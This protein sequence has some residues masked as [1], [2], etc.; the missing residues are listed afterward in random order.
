MQ[1]VREEALPRGRTVPH[2]R[3]QGRLGELQPL[4]EPGTCPEGD[5]ADKRQRLPEMTAAQ[6]TAGERD[7]LTCGNVVFWQHAL[8]RW[9]QRAEALGLDGSAAAM[10]RTFKRAVPEM[11]R[12]KSVRWN[13]VKRTIFH[14]AT[15]YLAADGW[16]FILE[17]D[18]CIAVERVL[19]HENFAGQRR[20]RRFVK[21]VIAPSYDQ[22]PPEQPLREEFG[23]QRT[24]CACPDCTRNCRHMSGYLIPA[25]LSRMA[26]EAGNLEVWAREHLF[27]SPGALVGSAAGGV[28]RIPT[29]V[30]ARKEDGSCIFLH[31]ELCSIHAV[32][33]FG[34]AFFDYHMS[35]GEGDRR[36]LKGLMSIVQDPPPS[37]YASLW[38]WLWARGKRA[39]APEESRRAMA[40]G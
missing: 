36:S 24:V 12:Q 26:P 5:K 34:C 16:R 31:G 27:A 4:E 35:V 8:H 17:G 9:S 15:R 22:T 21:T 1:N 3:P 29:L 7:L 25:D 28:F 11:I 32:A 38:T 39:P 6:G 33:P 20:Q 10:A 30:P 13:L 23:F 40:A 18:R 37:V 19:P 14:G 2:L